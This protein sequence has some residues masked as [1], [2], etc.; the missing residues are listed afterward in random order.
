MLCSFSPLSLH[1]GKSALHWPLSKQVTPCAPDI[2]QC[3]ADEQEN[4]LLDPG[5]TPD[6]LTINFPF[7]G[8]SG[9]SFGLAK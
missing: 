9:Q 3:F 5:F 2:S 7:D 8:I 6:P 1:V 4:V